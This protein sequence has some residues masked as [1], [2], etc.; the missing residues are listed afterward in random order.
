MRL[1]SKPGGFIRVYDTDIMP[2]SV[3]KSIRISED[4]TVKD[5]LD[6]MLACCSSS[7]AQD[8]LS[9]VLEEGSVRAVLGSNDCPLVLVKKL[10]EEFKHY[11]LVIEMKEGLKANKED[12]VKVPLKT[13]CVAPSLGLSRLRLH[14]SCS[15][16]SSLDSGYSAHS[17]C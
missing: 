16:L 14:S 1:N 3:Y 6:I 8:Q 10:V 2:D 13:G 12:P 11:K 7:I 15:S 17:V 5:V 9:L 4:T